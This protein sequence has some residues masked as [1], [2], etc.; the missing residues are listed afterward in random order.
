M[1]TQSTLMNFFSSIG[2]KKISWSLRRLHCPVHKN[3]LVL[4]VGSGG[5]PYLR[6][7]VLCDPFFESHDRFY[8]KLITDRITVNAFAE[9][10]PFKDNSFDFVIATSNTSGLQTITCT[11]ICERITYDGCN[12]VNILDKFLWYCFFK[13]LLIELF[14]SNGIKL[15]IFLKAVSL[16]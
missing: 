8:E 5:S 11:Y 13:F 12:M 4:E 16:L 15:F 9:S 1:K 10:L 6:S 14:I 2:L 3:D 7:N